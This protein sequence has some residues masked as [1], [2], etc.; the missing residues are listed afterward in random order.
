MVVVV[1]MM[2]MRRGPEQTSGDVGWARGVGLRRRSGR[3]TVSRG[4]RLVV[5][6][7]EWLVVRRGQG[8]GRGSR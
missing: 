5:H 8:E 1:V 4:G 2:V 7:R 6:G 3:A